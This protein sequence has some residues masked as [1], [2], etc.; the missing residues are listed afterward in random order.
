MSHKLLVVTYHADLLQF[1][2]FCHCLYLNWHG[3]KKLI[4]AIG[5]HTSTEQIKKIVNQQFD[6]LWQVEIVETVFAYELGDLEQQINKIYYSVNSG[7]EDIIVF[8]SKDFMLRPADFLTFKR[9]NKYRWTYRLPGQYLKDLGYDIGAIVEQPVDKLPAV[10][11]LT[12]WIWNVKQLGRYWDHL[13][14]KFGDFKSWKEFSA[15]NEI[16]GYYVYTWTDKNAP[17]KFLTSTESPLL[18]AGG[19]THQTYDG[20]VAQAQEFDQETTRIIWKHSRKLQDP[21]CLQVTRSV[22]IKYGIDKKIVD[23]VYGLDLVPA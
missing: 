15:G 14:T 9:D 16:Y 2:M 17:V 23:A 4:V 8:D 13:N 1:Q 12:P 10:L 19:W 11:N 6:H 21:R 22:L 3:N 5:K 18:V 7:V 20:I